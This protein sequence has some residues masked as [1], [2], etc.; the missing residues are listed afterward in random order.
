M[1]GMT[2]SPCSQRPANCCTVKLRWNAAPALS[3]SKRESSPL[4]LPLNTGKSFCQGQTGGGEPTCCCIQPKFC[5]LID[6]LKAQLLGGH[7]SVKQ[8]FVRPRWPYDMRPSARAEKYVCHCNSLGGVTWR[9]VTIT[10][11]MDRQTDRQSATQY[12]APS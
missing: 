4:W 9:S 11:R 6:V 10:G 12:A 7:T 2:I 8:E 3:I 1:I 5:R